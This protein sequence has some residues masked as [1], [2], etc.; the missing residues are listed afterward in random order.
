MGSFLIIANY[1]MQIQQNMGCMMNY[2][3]K[4]LFFLIYLYTFVADITIRYE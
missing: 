2:S 3:P 4:K 1:T